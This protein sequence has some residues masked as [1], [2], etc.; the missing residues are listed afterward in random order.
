MRMLEV[1]EIQRSLDRAT[2]RVVGRNSLV[3]RQRAL[4]IGDRACMPAYRCS[5]AA[6]TSLPVPRRRIP[7]SLERALVEGKIDAIAVESH[8]FP[9]KQ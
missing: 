1:A 4:H 7:A 8:A 3:S 2:D 6:A 9:F 5:Q